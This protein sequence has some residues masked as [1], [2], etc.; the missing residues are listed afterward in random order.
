M[1]R[2]IP[3][4]VQALIDAK[5]A[6]G[7]YKNEAELLREAL[8]SIDDFEEDVEAVQ[9]AIKKWQ[10]GDEGIPVDEAFELVRSRVEGEPNR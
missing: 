5:M 10:G 1:I 4:D 3:P 6:S 7:Q 8:S 9:S 2:H